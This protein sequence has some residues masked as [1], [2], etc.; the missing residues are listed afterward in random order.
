MRQEQAVLQHIRLVFAN[1]LEERI[2][3]RRKMRRGEKEGM[4]KAAF[5]SVLTSDQRFAGEALKVHTVIPLS[6]F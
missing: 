3:R 1:F 5:V 2:C 4:V 6:P